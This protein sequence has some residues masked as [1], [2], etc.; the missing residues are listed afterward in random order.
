MFIDLVGYNRGMNTT[1]NITQVTTILGMNIVSFRSGI[2]LLFL[3]IGV[4]IFVIG[5]T[6][7]H[8]QIQTIGIGLL[9]GAGVVAF[10]EYAELRDILTG[11][12]SVAAIFFSAMSISQARKIRQDTLEK[13]EKEGKERLLNEIIDWVEKSAQ[14]AIFRKTTD[15][16][17]LWTA[18]LNYKNSI[19]K[20]GYIK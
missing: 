6:K 17:E 14:A 20:S 4:I 1:D 12:A 15:K 9:G 19:G 18:M 8:L 7:K 5:S 13:F 2:I 16:S 11:F 10:V 3:V